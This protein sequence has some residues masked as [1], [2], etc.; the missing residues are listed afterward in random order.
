MCVNISYLAIIYQQLCGQN[1][2]YC[3]QCGYNFLLTPLAV[4]PGLRVMRQ[5]PVSAPSTYSIPQFETLSVGAFLHALVT[6]VKMSGFCQLL[7]QL[8]KYKV[9]FLYWM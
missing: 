4:Q 5:P 2:I 6:P 7:V 8:F 1:R 9:F 3:W